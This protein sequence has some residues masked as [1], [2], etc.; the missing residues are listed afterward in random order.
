MRK[1]VVI[2]S[3]RVF[4]ILARSPREALDIL[5]LRIVDRVAKVS[6][7]EAGE[8]KTT[9]MLDEVCAKD[10]FGFMREKLQVN[11]AFCQAL[12][13]LEKC[14]IGCTKLTLSNKLLAA[15]ANGELSFAVMDKDETQLFC[16]EKDGKFEAP[17]SRQLMEKL[18]GKI[19]ERLYDRL[20]TQ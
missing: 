17:V 11:E 10:L 18:K 19:P 7:V 5:K 15:F 8:A 1:Y 14:L 16:G 13:V 2:T 20:A 12:A 4:Q 9:P 6:N 3:V